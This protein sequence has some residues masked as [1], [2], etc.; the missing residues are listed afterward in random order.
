MIY[1][2]DE[3]KNIIAIITDEQVFVSPPYS[4]KIDGKNIQNQQEGD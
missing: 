2:I 3:N 1:I 4:V